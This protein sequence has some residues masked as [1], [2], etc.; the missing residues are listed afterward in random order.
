MTIA[1]NNNDDGVDDNDNEGADDNGDNDYDDVDDE[2]DDDVD[3]DDDEDNGDDYGDNELGYII[4]RMQSRI[5]KN[6][7]G[8]V[9]FHYF[10]TFFS[11]WGKQLTNR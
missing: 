8:E 10:S 4:K 9:C 5:R 7:T 11:P 2:D 1:D 6:H 3:D